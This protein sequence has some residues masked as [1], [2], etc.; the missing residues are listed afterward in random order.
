V[1]AGPIETFAV[2]VGDVD[3]D[4]HPDLVLTATVR[5]KPAETAM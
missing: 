1:N 4:G 5:L 3:Q 2:A